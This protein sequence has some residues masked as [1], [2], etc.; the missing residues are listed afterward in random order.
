MELAG[1]MFLHPSLATGDV[2]LTTSSQKLV[3]QFQLHQYFI[4]GG[5]VVD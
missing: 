5:F 2:T 3:F 4:P 1:D